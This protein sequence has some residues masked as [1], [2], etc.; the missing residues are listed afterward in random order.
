MSESARAENDFAERTVPKRTRRKPRHIIMGACLLCICMGLI[1]KDQIINASSK[2]FEPYVDRHDVVLDPSFS[3][4]QK[5]MYALTHATGRQA[6]DAVDQIIKSNDTRFA[7][8]FIEMILLQEVPPVRYYGGVH[9]YIQGVQQ[10]SGDATLQPGRPNDGMAVPLIQ[11]YSGTNLK[12]PEGFAGWKGTILSRIDS[13]YGEILR[14]GVPS[15]IRVAEIQYGGARWDKIP[16]LDYPQMIEASAAEY[17]GSEEPV[18]GIVVNG[19]A[20]AY[21]HKIVDWHEMVNDVIG[22][23]PVSLAYCTLCGTAIAFDGRGTDGNPRSFGSSGLLYRSNKL[24]FDRESFTLWNQFSGRPVL[25]PLAEQDVQL[26]HLPVVVS[27]WGDWKG[28]HPNTTVLDVNTGHERAYHPGRSYGPYFASPDLMFPAGPIN[29]VLPPKSRVFGLRLG[30]ASKAY[31]LTDLVSEKTI[32]DVVGGE[33]VAIIAQRGTITVD[34]QYAARLGGYMD[35]K[36]NVG[37]EVRAFERQGHEFRA[38]PSPGSVLDEKDQTWKV[39]ETA[40]VA[41]DQTPLSRIEG[42]QGFWFA[43]NAFNP[44]TTVYEKPEK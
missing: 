1:F 11:W 2:F 15:R 8:V 3:D 43:W 22:G 24:M 26:K 9:K 13:T 30:G 25:G 38:G 10:F 31:A 36:Y 4:D 12:E 34:G 42:V 32:N 18:F 5:L 29:P 19:D 44:K 20:R 6:E 40:L 28:N 33:P 14:D 35:V 39:T 27:S 21:P 41:D 16:S 17:L 7:A 23:V 37:G